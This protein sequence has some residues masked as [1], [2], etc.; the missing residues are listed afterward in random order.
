MPPR[1]R[2]R[3]ALAVKPGGRGTVLDRLYQAGAFKAVFPHGRGPGKQAVLVN[4]A[5]GVTGGDSFKTSAS[6]GPG[7]RLTLTTQAAERAYRACPD[8][9]GRIETRLTVEDGAR[10]HWVP[11]ETILFEGSALRRRMRVDMAPSARLLLVEPVIFGRT[12]MGEAVTDASFDD[13]IEVWRDGDPLY[14]DAMA[15]GGDLQAHLSRPFI[16]G[17][18]RA[19]ASLVLVA[20]EAEAMLPR[21][22]Q[23]LPDTAGASLLRPDLLCLRL[24]AADG[25]ELRR[26]LMPLLQTLSEDDLPRP[27]MI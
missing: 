1:A 23:M 17:G 20:P 14:L 15:L 3:V 9:T 2:G 24:L 5:G 10:L 8:E 19:M 22:R 27:W 11:Q 25:F 21:V 12:A 4:T 18:A 13:R 7:T 26:S 16:G 6:A